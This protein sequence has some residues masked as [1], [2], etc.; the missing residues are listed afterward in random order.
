M[1]IISND[2]FQTLLDKIAEGLLIDNMY[3]IKDYLVCKK[4]G[5][6]WV[7]DPN[8]SKFREDIKQRVANAE[9]YLTD[10]GYRFCR[11]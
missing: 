2:Q 9:R 7:K 11:S 8:H 5:L 6:A 4:K 10:R 1:R 3:T